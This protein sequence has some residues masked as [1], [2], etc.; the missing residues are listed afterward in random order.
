MN[1]I[2]VII[3]SALLSL[4][5]SVWAVDEND[6][7]EEPTPIV[8]T[9]DEE[10]IEQEKIEESQYKQ[11]ISKRKIAKKFLAAMGGV[12]VSSF[13]IFFLL[14][15]YNRVR[16]NFQVQNKTSDKDVSLETPQDV[17]EAVKTFL[18]KTKW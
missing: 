16:E 11:P 5:I 10:V 12:A 2:F 7:I 17:N 15:V 18:D 3:L 14:T 13:A 4:P 8:N 6:P 9:L 1:R